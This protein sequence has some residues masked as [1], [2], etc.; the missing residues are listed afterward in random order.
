MNTRRILLGRKGERLATAFLKRQGYSIIQ[1]NYRCKYG[2]ID[3]IAKDGTALV[4]VEVRTV[5][6]DHFGDPQQTINNRKKRHISK[7]ALH[8][9]TKYEI[10]DVEVRFDVI[11]VSLLPHETK[12]DLFKN[13]FEVMK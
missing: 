4:F 7:V 13:A 5:S 2:E 3:I 10:R 8:Y 12:M 11:A 6:S 9:L 1:R